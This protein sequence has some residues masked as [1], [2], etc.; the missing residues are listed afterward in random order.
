MNDFSEVKNLIE[1][2]GSAWATFKKSNDERFADLKSDVDSLAK[3]I[4]RAPLRGLFGESSSGTNAPEM[5]AFNVFVRTGTDAREQ[6]SMSIGSDPDGGYLVPSP[7]HNQIMSV[8]KE[9]SPVRGLARIV[10]MGPGSTTSF[11]VS[12]GGTGASWVGET[13]SRAATDTPAL[14]NTTIELCE[15]YALPMLTQ[16]LL[17]DSGFDV[18]A[19]MTAEL[20]ERFAEVEGQAFI[21]GNGI[22]QPRGLFTYTTAATADSSRTWGQFEHVNSGA[23]GSFHTDKG[24]KLITLVMKLKP[25]YRQR[26][27]WLM[28]T[29]VLE[30]I[31]LLKEATTDRYIFEPSLAAGVPPTLLG[32]PV[33]VD[34]RMPALATGSLS[35]A[36]GDWQRA[37]TVVQRPPIRVLRDP[38]STKGSVGFYSTMRTGGGAVD[39]NAAKFLRFAA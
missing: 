34:D 32:Y 17:D 25:Q 1:A 2:Q 23:N 14:A 18:G 7:M 24:D 6:K 4:G 8:M 5:K 13:A 28:S 11:V 33:F 35:C 37:Y 9:M 31:R 15:L 20:A 26:A 29:E 30:D 22:A 21:D 39:F 19:W 36:F 3:E 12:R 38:Y 27:S 10:D 16:R